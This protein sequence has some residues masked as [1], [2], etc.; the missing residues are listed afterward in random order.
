MLKITIEKGETETYLI[1]EGSLTGAWVAELYKAVIDRLTTTEVIR[2]E[3]S[4][5]H[6]VNEQGLTLLRDLTKWGVTLSRISPFIKE[7]LKVE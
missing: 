6:Y 2:L 7:L 1:L 3:L 5:V 4:N